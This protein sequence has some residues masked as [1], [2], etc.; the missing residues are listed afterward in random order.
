MPFCSG[1]KPGWL[2]SLT[3][4]M[5][6]RHSHKPLHS[7]SLYVYY[8]LFHRQNI[9][10]KPSL[11]NSWL[12]TK[13]RASRSTQCATFTDCVAF[14]RSAQ[15]LRRYTQ[16]QRPRSDKV[17][18][19]QPIRSSS[20][21]IVIVADCVDGTER[22]SLVNVAYMLYVKTTTFENHQQRVHQ[23]FFYLLVK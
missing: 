16:T 22:P 11:A 20:I 21:P 23:I 3:Y 8:V 9:P 18:V 7:P 19:P 5:R 1:T 12:R 4:E 14:C 6:S 17:V 13:R 2:A 10:L 15:E